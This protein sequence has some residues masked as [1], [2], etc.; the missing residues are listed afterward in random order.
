LKREATGLARGVSLRSG[1]MKNTE[2]FLQGR[3]TLSLFCF[4][5]DKYV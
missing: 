5:G 2:E 4:G 1:K 3:F